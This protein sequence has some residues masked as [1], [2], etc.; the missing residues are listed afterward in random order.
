[1]FVRRTLTPLAAVPDKTQVE[2]IDMGGLRKQ[3]GLPRP[4]ELPKVTREVPVQKNVS[5]NRIKTGNTGRTLRKV[6]K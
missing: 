1:M 5:E 4:V 2:K 3:P 6:N